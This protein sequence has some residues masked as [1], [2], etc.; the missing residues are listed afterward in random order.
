MKPA[1]DKDG[2]DV[3]VATRV[4]VVELSS[5]FLASL[6]E[7]E[8]DDV[9]SMIGEVFEVYEVDQYGSPWVGK[10]W[11]DLEGGEYRGHSLALDSW[12]MEVVDQEV[13][14]KN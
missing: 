13:T 6:P 12:E 3:V 4:R 9:M 7:N 14:K 1:Q 2:R 11:N 5:S 10:G 8:I